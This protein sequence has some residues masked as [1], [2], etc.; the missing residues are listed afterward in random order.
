[1]KFVNNFYIETLLMW[2]SLLTLWWSHTFIAI[3]ASYSFQSCGR[4]ELWS[5]K[6]TR[7]SW[8]EGIGKVCAKKDI[9]ISGWES[10]CVCFSVQ[11]QHVSVSCFLLFCVKHVK[12]RICQLLQDRNQPW[13]WNCSCWDWPYARK[14]KT[15]WVR[16]KRDWV[17][18]KMKQS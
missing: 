6:S 12:H 8:S 16:R 5:W 18:I 15:T 17:K 1:M 14:W 10:G 7:S 2:C 9:Y 13:A 4:T 11:A 3:C